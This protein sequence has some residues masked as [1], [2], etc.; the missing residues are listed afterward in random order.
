MFIK[1]V[2]H[3]LD[4]D[5]LFVDILVTSIVYKIFP[6]NLIR[7]AVVYK[8]FVDTA[9]QLSRALNVENVRVTK[10]FAVRGLWADFVVLT[11]CLECFALA[12]PWSVVTQN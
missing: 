4:F 7:H 2:A 6:T 5:G 1:F 9:R 11:P 8:C 12:A 10:P 3:G